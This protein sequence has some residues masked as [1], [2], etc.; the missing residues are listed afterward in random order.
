MHI[1]P[2]IPSDTEPIIQLD[3]KVTPKKL[4]DIRR[5]RRKDGSVVE[6]DTQVIGYMA[7]GLGK[8]VQ[9]LRIKA[10]RPLAYH[11]LLQNLIE[12]TRKQKKRKVIYAK[13]ALIPSL[14]NI[15]KMNGFVG[16]LE[17]PSAN[18][19]TMSISLD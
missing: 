1:R 14:L 17:N 7:Y 18:R 8:D 12:R 13:V 10:D 15:F 5:H 16:N 2:L 19:V 11:K 6:L 4:E 3:K 9:I